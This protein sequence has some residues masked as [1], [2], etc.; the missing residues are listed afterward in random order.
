MASLLE[1]CV[2]WSVT[3]ISSRNLGGSSLSCAVRT[4]VVI[5]LVSA[6]AEFSVISPQEGQACTAHWDTSSSM[7]VAETQTPKWSQTSTQNM[8]MRRLGIKSLLWWTN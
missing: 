3:G 7:R 5:A 8:E 6:G 2:G 1:Y 4:E